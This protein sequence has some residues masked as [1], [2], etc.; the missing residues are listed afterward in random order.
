MHICRRTMEFESGGY[1]IGNS[2]IEWIGKRRRLNAKVMPC[3]YATILPTTSCR[4]TQNPAKKKTTTTLHECRIHTCTDLSGV[5][6]RPTIHST[7]FFFADMDNVALHWQ[8]IFVI[9][10]CNSDFLW[11][12]RFEFFYHGVLSLHFPPAIDKWIYLL[13]KN[14]GIL[15]NEGLTFSDLY[16]WHWIRRFS[17]SPLKSL[18]YVYAN[19]SKGN[20]RWVINDAHTHTHTRKLVQHFE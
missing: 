3:V 20:K 1:P 4:E 8:K 10:K 7:L 13:G 16:E 12:S 17:L 6:S 11:I 5:F 18:K 15:M 9:L 19:C 2:N 14:V